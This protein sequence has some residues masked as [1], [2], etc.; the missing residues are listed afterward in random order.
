MRALL[1]SGGLDSTAIAKW[2]NPEYAITIDYGQIPANAEIAASTAISRQLGIKH[3]IICADCSAVGLGDMA[4]SHQ[5]DVAPIPEWWPFRN[6]LI[7]TLAAALGVRL[8]I[9]ELIIGCLKTDGS[10]ADG[11]ETFISTMSELLG[12]QEGE[13]FL[14]APAIDLTAPEL[15]TKSGAGRDLFGWCHSCHVSNYACGHC[16][17]CVKHFQVMEEVFG[18]GYYKRSQNCLSK[19]RMHPS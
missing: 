8:G 4:N 15:I 1:L 16:R 13:V 2:M 7:V 19:I 18:E 5:I 14:T 11:R 3:E 9:H 17:G 10:H 12:M 6:Q